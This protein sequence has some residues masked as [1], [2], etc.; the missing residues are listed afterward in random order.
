MQQHISNL[1][2]YFSVFSA[3]MTH[4][5]HDLPQNLLKMITK[6]VSTVLLIVLFY[7]LQYVF[8]IEFVCSCKAGLHLNG[9]VYILAP[10]LIFTLVVKVTEPFRE[11]RIFQ[12]HQSECCMDIHC[13][14]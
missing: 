6:A 3:R 5:A 12:L 14:V 9:I 4:I 11:T 2:N 13:S 1:I 10:P 8:D 7:I